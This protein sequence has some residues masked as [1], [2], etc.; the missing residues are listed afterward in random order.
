MTFGNNVDFC[1]SDCQYNLLGRVVSLVLFVGLVR[2]AEGK[3]YI[4]Q[5][6][7]LWWSLLWTAAGQHV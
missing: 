1:G 5:R 6:P 7:L 4:P 3:V 2:P